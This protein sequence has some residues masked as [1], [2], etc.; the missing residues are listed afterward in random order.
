MFICLLSIFYRFNLT[1]NTRKI[2][3]VTVCFDMKTAYMVSI[4]GQYKDQSLSQ[5]LSLLLTQNVK[6]HRTSSFHGGN[7]W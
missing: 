3:S 4:K 1:F 6:N 5:F 2:A 7:R